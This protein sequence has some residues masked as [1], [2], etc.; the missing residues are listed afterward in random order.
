MMK[1]KRHRFFTLIELLV[2]IAIIAIL[3]SMLL[4]ALSKAREKAKAIACTSQ[5]KQI[6]L[7]LAMYINDNDDHTPFYPFKSGTKYTN[8][9][10]RALCDF[11][12]AGTPYL[13]VAGKAPGYQPIF[14][15]P[16]ERKLDGGGNMSTVHYFRFDTYQKGVAGYDDADPASYKPIS[17]KAS[18][19]TRSSRRLLIVEGVHGKAHNITAY[20]HT[21]MEYRHAGTMVDLWF[22]GHVEPVKKGYWEAW[23]PTHQ[24]DHNRV[25]YY[26]DAYSW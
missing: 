14:V 11:K 3:A 2:V 10:F 8:D 25:W 21:A 20:N 22:D 13:G 26:R 15:C 4:P 5:Q 18:R 19:I 1:A 6:G 17:F 12:Y 7:G 23:Y 9:T 16:A 24:A